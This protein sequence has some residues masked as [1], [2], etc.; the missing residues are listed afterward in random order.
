MPIYSYYFLC[1]SFESTEY[2]LPKKLLW[3]RCQHYNKPVRTD[4]PTW[5]ILYYY[6]IS[7][8]FS[9]ILSHRYYRMLFKRAEY[10]EYVM[11]DSFTQIII[12]N[13]R[14]LSDYSREVEMWYWNCQLICILVATLTIYCLLYWFGIWMWWIYKCILSSF[15][16]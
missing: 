10:V 13:M 12:R 6:R 1:F 8:L 7:I 9:S 15:P 3:K 14:W 16:V 5:Y 11:V 4:S 2:W